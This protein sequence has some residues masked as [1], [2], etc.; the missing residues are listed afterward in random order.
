M[1]YNFGFDIKEDYFNW[2]CEGVHID[3]VERSYLLLARDLHAKKF[4]AVVP[5]DENRALDGIELREDYLGEMN[6]PEYCC[7]DIDGDCSVFEMLIGLAKRIGFE[8]RNPTDL[9]MK[10]DRVG[11]WF[12]EMIDNLGLMGFDDESYYELD[13]EDAVDDILEVLLRREYRS[14]GLGG[15]FPLRR[16]SEDQRDVEIWYQMSA[17]LNENGSV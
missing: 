9:R 1:T 13:G 17:Y 11:Y 7:A 2:L 5:H 6:L 14:S 16:A 15:L 4:Y 3:Q 8:T 12:W 10:S